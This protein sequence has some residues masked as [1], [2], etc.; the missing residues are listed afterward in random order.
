MNARIALVLA[1]VCVV[2]T[3]ATKPRTRPPA[4]YTPP[5]LGGPVGA[6]QPAV[7]HAMEAA[8]SVIVYA[9]GDRWAEGSPRAQLYGREVVALESATESW[10]RHAVQ[11]LSD[12]VLYQDRVRVY[13][14]PSDGLRS[15]YVVMFS[16]ADTVTALWLLGEPSVEVRDRKGLAGRG[17]PDR[18]QLG[19]LVELARAAFPEDARIQRM[20]LMPAVRDRYAF[21]DSLPR[22][23]GDPPPPQAP[24][25]ASPQE[26]GPV[27][28]QV[29]VGTDGRVGETRVIHSVPALDRAAVDWVRRLRFRPALSRGRAVPCWAAVPVEFAQH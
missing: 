9:L 27:L 4:L 15:R 29:R 5:M 14:K 11:L 17:H 12:V 28:V 19:A 10:R 23:L 20:H 8:D 16:G 21:V 18:V 22:L 3:A 7:L 25:G 6:P 13:N 2:A 1:L 26:V 24:A